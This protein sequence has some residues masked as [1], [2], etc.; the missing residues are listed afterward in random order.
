MARSVVLV[1]HGQS[2][3]NAGCIL[4]GQADIAWSAL[5]RQQDD[6]LDPAIS[7][8]NPCRVTTSDLV[9]TSETAERLG[10]PDAG[11]EPRLREINV[12]I[13]QGRA[14][15]ELQ[16]EDPVS[17]HACQ[18]GTHRPKKGDLWDKFV[19]RTAAAILE[20]AAESGKTLLAPCHGGVIRALLLRL[21]VLAPRQIIPVAR[22]S[23]TALR[24]SGDG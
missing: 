9:R 19:K 20:E 14:I 5:E 6:A 21:V 3:W 7:A 17:D 24:L 15:V 16:A 22:G 13:L 10:L 2:E 11:R 12:V 18:A 1:Q 4:Q 8:L 23:M